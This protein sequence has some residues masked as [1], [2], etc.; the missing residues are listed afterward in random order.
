[1]YYFIF[2]LLSPWPSV[3]E[4]LEG[5]QY[6]LIFSVYDYPHLTV[7]VPHAIVE[8]PEPYR[9]YKQSRCSCRVWGILTVS[10]TET[11][12]Y[13]QH[14]YIGDQCSQSYITQS[15][16]AVFLTASQCPVCQ[17]TIT[18]TALKDQNQAFVTTTFMIY[19]LRPVKRRQKKPE[20]C[21]C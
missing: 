12:L 13:A 4:K 18:P 9:G 14:K 16:K 5:L 10:M 6:S 2:S 11:R 21:K 3:A 20:T 19:L 8:T 15:E 17:P 7:L 1:M